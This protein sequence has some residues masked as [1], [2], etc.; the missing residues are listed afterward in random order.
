MFQR[1]LQYFK[2]FS[3]TSKRLPYCFQGL[4][5]YGKILIYMLKLFSLNA[6]LHY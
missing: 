6:R 5:T 1:K 3:R 4:K 2:D